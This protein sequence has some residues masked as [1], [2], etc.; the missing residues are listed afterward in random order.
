M[1]G[2][3][4]SVVQHT[5]RAKDWW[6][7]RENRF[8]GKAGKLVS[9]KTSVRFHFDSVFK[10]CVLWTLCSVFPLTVNETLK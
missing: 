7:P 4:F 2:R 8:G 6:I 3:M 10:R 5:N 9:R 1:P